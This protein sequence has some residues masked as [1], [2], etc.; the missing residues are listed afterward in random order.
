MAT[1]YEGN[2]ITPEQIE[3]L[4]RFN[5]GKAPVKLKTSSDFNSTIAFEIDEAW[6]KEHEKDA[7]VYWLLLPYQIHSNYFD[8]REGDIYT[9]SKQYDGELFD[10][11]HI[12]KRFRVSGVDREID[13]DA[14]R[15]Y[16]CITASLVPID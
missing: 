1:D 13:Q 8:V 16:L 10:P 14:T 4:E 9:F 3:G 15:F 2:P 6:R 7:D 11:K 12:I 5:D